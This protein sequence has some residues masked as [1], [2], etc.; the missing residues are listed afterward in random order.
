MRDLEIYNTSLLYV[1]T[2]VFSSFKHANL[3][4][5]RIPAY[6]MPVTSG[7]LQQT[8]EDI[9]SSDIELDACTW[10]RRYVLRGDYFIKSE[11]EEQK[12]IVRENGSVVRPF[13]PKERLLNEYATLR[14]VAANTTIPVP[15]H[16]LYMADGLMHLATERIVHARPLQDLPAEKTAA[17]R[18]AVD[19]QI[20]RDVLPQLRAIRRDVIGSVAVSL[21]VVPPLRI[22]CRDD[23]RWPRITTTQDDVDNFVLCHNDLSAHNI[24]VD[25]DTFAI[26]AIIDWEYA[27]FY[28]ERFEIPLWRMLTPQD[29]GRLV[30]EVRA[31]DLAFFGLQPGDLRDC[32]PPGP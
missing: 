21:P 13:W 17:A 11:L 27:G 26:R 7:T 14:F 1:L 22:F 25:P 16:W 23:R 9:A 6:E 12:L 29:R 31:R 15:R 4:P 8:L 30:E 24:F 10:E 32:V 18:K 3:R 20:Q 2:R 28:P 5:R 19:E